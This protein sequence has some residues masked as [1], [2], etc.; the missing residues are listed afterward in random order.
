[1][2]SGDT[3][4]IRELIVRPVRVP[5]PEPHR[6]ASGVVAESPLVLT[7]V[8]TDS[9]V[10]GHGMVFT[11][12][13]A[14]LAPVADLIRNCGP[15]VTGLPLAPAEIEQ[16]LARRFRLLGTQ[17]LVGMAMAAIDMALWDALARGLGMPLVRLLGGAA[18]PVRC[19]GP[20]GYD[21]EDGS[22]AT[23]ARWVS[24][25]FTGVKAKIGYPTVD[26]DVAVIRAVRKAVGP[27]VSIMVDYN[28][29]LVP[30]EAVERVRRL[31]AEGLAWIEEPTLAHDYA[32]HAMVAREARTP[33]QCGENWWG[34]T[35]MRH[36]IEAGASDYVMPDVMKIGGVTGWL[37]AAAIAQAFGLP[38]SS[39]LWPELSARLLCCTPTSHWLEYSDWWNPVLKTPLRVENGMAV[40]SDDDGSGIEWDEE[41]VRRF[42]V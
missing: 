4:L 5:M 10:V 28:Q 13:P 25:G 18:K 42:A 39:H 27:E 6:T 11:Y 9:G 29:C 33:I 37:R 2:A 22:A 31:D 3:A 12:T 17:G 34:T 19:Y 38:V 21:G 35:D 36:A 26:E 32:G 41:A 24:R 7:D 8:V 1:M 30:A 15:L 14:A 16:S 23:A 20:V 40:I